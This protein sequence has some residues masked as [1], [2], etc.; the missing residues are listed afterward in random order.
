MNDEIDFPLMI[1]IILPIWLLITVFPLRSFSQLK[2]AEDQFRN[3]EIREALTT[4]NQHLEKK[5]A[6]EG[7]FLRAAIYQKLDSLDK[8]LVDLNAVLHFDSLHYEA[9]FERALIYFEQ[10]KYNFASND[11]I[12]LLN[13]EPN[14]ATTKIY[15]H[16]DPITGN[17]TGLSTA[18]SKMKDQVY[19]YL[20]LIALEQQ[21][22]EKAGLYFD[23][24][25]AEDDAKPGYFVNKGMSISARGDTLRAIDVIKKALE[26]D[27]KN[28]EAHYNLRLLGYIPDFNP[29]AAEN[30]AMMAYNAYHD[31]DFFEAYQLYDKA[32][33]ND[34]GNASLYH[35]KGLSAWKSGIKASAYQSVSKAIELDPENPDFTSTLANFYFNDKKY[36]NAIELYDLSLAVYENDIWYYNRGLAYY[37]LKNKTMACQDIKNASDMG[38]DVASRALEKI[39]H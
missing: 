9:L 38:L 34:P 15:F 22:Y 6:I 31:G 2:R 37:Y 25:I 5:P 4:V 17:A 28:R 24:A 36:D 29:L 35:E 18:V 21:Y 20:G 27:S 13:N 39:C 32:I 8:A 26:L 3:N 23:S 19:N 11:L 14:R 33:N 30:H 1:K 10:D 7:Y 12:R 16:M